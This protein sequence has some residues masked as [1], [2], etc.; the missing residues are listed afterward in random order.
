MSR[1]VR[2]VVIGASVVAGLLV[3]YYA[4]PIGLAIIS[5]G[6]ICPY[7]PSG[8][9]VCGGRTDAGPPS[10]P[11]YVARLA[12]GDCQVLGIRYRGTTAQGARI[13]FTLTPDGRELVESGFNF[14]RASKCPRGATGTVYSNGRATVDPSGRI[15]NVADLTGTVRG[16]TASGVLEDSKICPGKKFEWIA[17][18]EP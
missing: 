2:N 11:G 18:R 14:V 6:E 4:L 7:S 9:T 12:S 1:G 15:K 10:V 3:A 8:T 5:L 16:A 13:C 17:Q